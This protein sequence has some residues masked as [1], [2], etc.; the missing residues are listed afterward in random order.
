MIDRLI[1]A[2][3]SKRAD[4]LNKHVRS[5]RIC[6]RLRK[7]RVGMGDGSKYDSKT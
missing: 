4:T 7:K 6:K 1:I 2:Y 3:I 5:K